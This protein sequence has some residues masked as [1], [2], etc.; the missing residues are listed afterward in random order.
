[1]ILS[2]TEFEEQGVTFPGGFKTSG[3]RTGLKSAGP[4]VALIVSDE[5]CPVAGVFTTN[6]VKA[7]CVT[8][9]QR[10]VALGRAQAIFVN[11]GNANAC[12]GPQGD[13]DTETMA[14]LVSRN[15]NI[16]SNRV[17]IA[18]TGVIGHL[19]PME[20]I[21]AGVPK[22]VTT[23][24]QSPKADV[25]AAK[26]IMTTDLRQKMAAIEFQSDNWL[27]P[28]RFGGMCKGSGM[29]AP[30]MATMLCFV[31]TDAALPQ[32]LLQ[33]ALV[34]AIEKTF[35]R[36]TVDGD[37]S[38]NDMTLVMASGKSSI[39]I[40]SE[41]PA[42]EDFVSALQTICLNLAK[43]VV[44]DGEG[45]TK[46][47]QV[48]VKGT[49]SEADAVKIARTI[50]ESPLVKTALFGSD[51]NWGRIMMAAGR[52]GIPFDFNL[53]DVFIGSTIVFERGT[54]VPFD[55]DA[56]SDYLKQEEIS[57]TVDLHSGDASADIWTC[58]FSYDYVKI[59]AEYH[60]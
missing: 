20:K 55:R 48:T 57:L 41:G 54:G 40:E 33:T 21:A 51:P 49:Q 45:A 6:Q 52:A 42:F 39:D 28:I 46:L 27:G 59:N 23:L 26:A 32:G 3:V 30:N 12:N 38:T 16:P 4:D 24:E 2:A 10:V 18:S 36:I 56:C 53:T 25:I 19:M 34:R 8:W 14:T 7:S 17:L 44:R 43:L 29:I 50:A 37:T 58:D 13:R 15:L 22:A 1:M 5:P 9:S 11:A 60:T 47:A 31:T 35:N